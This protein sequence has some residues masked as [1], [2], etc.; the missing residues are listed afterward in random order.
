MYV[1]SVVYKN[2]LNKNFQSCQKVAR[3]IFPMRSRPNF[4][5]TGTPGVGK[6]TFSGMLAQRFNL[7]HI[8]VSRLIADKHLWY[9]KDEARD[10]TIYDEQLLDDEI[11]KIMNE[12]PNGGV[13][14]DFHCSDIVTKDM[15][16]FVLVLRCD[17]D[18]LYKR[19]FARNYD[20]NKIIENVDSEIFRVIFDEVIEDFPSEMIKEIQS[21]TMADLDH[22]VE[23]VAQLMNPTQ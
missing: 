17:S 5:V 9:E 8:P 18:I 11:E 2:Y 20:Q 21:D 23:M 14:F 4:L 19:L 3:P 13:I 22:A 12:N 15:V 16:D 7:L 10:C 6:T 1:F